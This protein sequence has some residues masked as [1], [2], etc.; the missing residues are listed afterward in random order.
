MTQFKAGYILDVIANEITSFEKEKADKYNIDAL[1]MQGLLNY[2]SSFEVAGTAFDAPF[3]YEKLNPFLATINNIITRGLPT[4]APVL[5][6]EKFAEIIK[7]TKKNEE[8][9]SEI[10][11]VENDNKIDWNTIFEILHFIEPKL[12]ITRDK[13]LGVLGSEGE[14]DFINNKLAEFQFCKQILQSQRSFE[15]INKTMPK[16]TSVDFSYEIPYLNIQ[17]DVDG[18]DTFIE[19]LVTKGII[20]EFDG[21]HHKTSSHRIFMQVFYF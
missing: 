15:T 19:Q 1:K 3:E 12:N 6:E 18:N 11:Y 21:K 10:N 9:K 13:Y 2:I 17:N 14:W 5:I 20:F 16:G 7:A 8:K 4:R